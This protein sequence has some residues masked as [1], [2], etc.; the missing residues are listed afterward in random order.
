MVEQRLCGTAHV[1]YYAQPIDNQGTM[2]IG[3]NQ[4]KVTL[5]DGDSPLIGDWLSYGNVSKNDHCVATVIKQAHLVLL[6]L[7][8]SFFKVLTTLNSKK[9]LAEAYV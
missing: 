4:I 5:S 8:A 3:N 2:S 7:T 9:T 1:K 6:I